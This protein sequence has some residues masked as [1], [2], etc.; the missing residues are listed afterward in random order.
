MEKSSDFA[1]AF[2]LAVL[3]VKKFFI[4]IVLVP[5]VIVSVVLVVAVPGVMVVHGVT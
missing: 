1:S 3:I 5:G 4:I 2:G